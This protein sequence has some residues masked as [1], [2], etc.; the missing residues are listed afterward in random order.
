M[1]M[2]KAQ[3]RAAEEEGEEEGDRIIVVGRVGEGVGANETKE[4]AGKGK[5]MQ[6]ARTNTNVFARV[7]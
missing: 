7:E 1:K 6:K 4:R 5:D 2:K 3:Q